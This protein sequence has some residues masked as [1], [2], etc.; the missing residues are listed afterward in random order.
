MRPRHVLTGLAVIAAVAL[1]IA[2]TPRGTGQ[3][4]ARRGESAFRL[5]PPT[6][7]VVGQA[8]HR[9]KSLRPAHLTHARATARAFLRGYLP[10]LY[11]HG[12]VRRIRHVSAAVR[13][14]LARGRARATPAQRARRPRLVKLTVVAQARGVVAAAALIDDR[15]IAPYRLTFTLVRRGGRWI[16]SALGS[17]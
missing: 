1:V 11:R 6:P 12:G 9:E 15:G 2:T 7:P 3:V 17:A 5:A 4:P 10:F 13:R 8:R 14:G 16:V